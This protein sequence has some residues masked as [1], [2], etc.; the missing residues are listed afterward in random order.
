[1]ATPDLHARGVDFVEVAA[2]GVH[3]HAGDTSPRR[4]TRREAPERRDFYAIGV[5]D[6]HTMPL[7]Q[8]QDCGNVKRR[9]RMSAEGRH[10]LAH[11][12]GSAREG[13]ISGD[14]S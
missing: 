9:R 2:G 3:E 13:T 8:L 11:G 1:M 6:E 10:F 5:D 7:D 4:G 12:H 14:M